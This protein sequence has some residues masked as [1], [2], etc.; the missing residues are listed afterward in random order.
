MNTK[1]G[2]SGLGEWF[3]NRWNNTVDSNLLFNDNDT[4][5]N[6]INVTETVTD[7]SRNSFVGIKFHWSE[8]PTKDEK[9]Y[10]Q[11]CQELGDQ[12]LINQ[13]LDLLF[14][15]S[16]NCIFSDDMLSSF[17]TQKSSE[18]ITTPGNASFNIFEED[19]DPTDYYLLGADTAESLNGAYCTIEIF[20][21]RT[22]NQVG[23]LEYKYGSYTAFGQDID[24]VFRWLRNRIGSDNIILAVENNT[25]G[26]ATIEHLL[27]HVDDI[28]YRSYLY[29]EDL[30][31]NKDDKY[32]VSTTGMTKP[33]MVGCL[34]QFVNENTDCIKSQKLVD[35]FGNIEKTNSGTIRANGYSDLF[36]AA[37]F[38]ALI[39]QKKA[40]DIMPL[41][42]QGSPQEY[43][44]KEINTFTEILGMSNKQNLMK[45]N[46]Q[47]LSV[48]SFISADDSYDEDEVVDAFGS[49]FEDDQEEFLPFFNS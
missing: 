22:F 32:G 8:D 13:E 19:L 16:T 9:W 23:E 24:F 36:M 3:F 45:N 35:Q 29:K 40:L 4:W 2:T 30:K 43:Q 17:N 48:D 27:Y 44:K 46:K 31:H 18:T 38:C 20:G 37:C 10:Q 6:D 26:H 5:R 42:T 7:P 1:N 47:K 49:M 14:V 34:T 15:G 12:R 41:I 33:L 28:D 25:I 11:Q 21:F 39:R